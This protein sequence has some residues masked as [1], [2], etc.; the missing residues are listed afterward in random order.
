MVGKLAVFILVFLL[1]ASV[2]SQ[3]IGVQTVREA[4]RRDLDYVRSL[5]SDDGK[6]SSGFDPSGSLR[7]QV[8]VGSMVAGIHAGLG[9]PE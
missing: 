1:L 6:L 7:G 8:L 5:L 2:Q 3:E 4:L 9:D